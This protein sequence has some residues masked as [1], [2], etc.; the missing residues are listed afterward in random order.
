MEVSFSM[1]IPTGQGSDREAPAKRK[2]GNTTS[3]LISSKELLYPENHTSESES[4][5]VH[6][7]VFV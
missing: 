4:S 6:G 2:E 7:Q 3:D 5:S 1:G